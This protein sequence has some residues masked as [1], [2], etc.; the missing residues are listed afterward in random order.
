MLLISQILHCL[1]DLLPWKS[2]CEAS[3]FN[4]H[5]RFGQH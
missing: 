4:V 5:V 2:A 1:A 3:W